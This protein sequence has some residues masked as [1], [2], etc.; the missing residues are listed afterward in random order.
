MNVETYDNETKVNLKQTNQQNKYRPHAKIFTDKSKTVQDYKD[1]VDINNIVQR[2]MV[3]G[4]LPR[5]NRTPVYADVSEVPDYQTALGIVQ[6]ARDLFSSLP[7]KTRAMFNNDPVGMMEWLQ[8]PKNLGQAVD[9]GLI[10]QAPNERIDRL[11]PTTQ[12]QNQLQSTTIQPKN[13]VVNKDSN[14]G[15]ASQSAGTA[16]SQG[17]RGL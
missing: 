5:A 16:D 4:E 8:D 1:E 2:A 12:N 7:S 10:E 6:K 15:N 14:A 3:T 9:L 17:V 13:N 11:Q